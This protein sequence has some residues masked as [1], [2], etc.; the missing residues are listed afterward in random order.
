M[1]TKKLVFISIGVV[2]VFFIGR[3]VINPLAR[4]CYACTG[5]QHYKDKRITSKIEFIPA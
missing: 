2:L 4:V 1:N 5:I 3:G